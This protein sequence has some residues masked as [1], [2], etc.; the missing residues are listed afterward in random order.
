[1]YNFTYILLEDY[2]PLRCYTMSLG[3]LFALS[4]EL[5]LQSETKFLR[6]LLVLEDEGDII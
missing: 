1:M 6:R 5:F 3:L 4:E 2:S